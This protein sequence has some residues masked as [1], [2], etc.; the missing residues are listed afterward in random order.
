MLAPLGPDG[1]GGVSTC[2]ILETF[3]GASLAVHGSPTYFATMI[4]HRLVSSV[5][6]LIAVQYAVIG[7][8][9]ICAGDHSEGTPDVP[10]HAAH[11]GS[12]SSTPA[13]PCAPDAQH[14]AHQ[15]SSAGCMAMVGCST[16]GVAAVVA[17]QLSVAPSTT[18]ASIRTILTPRSVLT[19]PDTPPP[20]A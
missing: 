17:P 20:I 12:G 8:G 18:V 4:W 16:T 6:T 1:P 2:Q 9:S 13:A 3:I 5:L 19:P 7:G 11:E 14:P 15:G 10:A